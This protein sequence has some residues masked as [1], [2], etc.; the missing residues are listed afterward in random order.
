M[1]PLTL[2]AV[3]AGLCH[4]SPAAGGELYG[5][6]T[7]RE[8]DRH[9]GPIRWDKNENFWDDFLDATKNDRVKVS[10]DEGFDL[11]FF[12]WRIVRS[13][14]RE[15]WVRSQ[16]A[17]PFGHLSSI[18]SLSKKLVVLELKSGERLEI[19]ESGDLGNSMRGVVIYG[20]DGGETELDWD[21]IEKVE[22][23]EAK[24]GFREED[25]LYGTVE[26]TVGEFVGFVVW[27][28]D[29]S[30]R[31]DILDGDEDDR[32]RKVPMGSIRSIENIGNGAKVTLNSGKTLVL[33]GSNDVDG[34]NRG[35]DVTIAEM[36]RVT[37]QWSEFQRV[38]FETPPPS[39]RYDDFD[40]G[41]L[42]HG[43]VTT[44]AGDELGGQIVWDRDER[45][46]W[47]TLSG[48]LR[49]VEFEIHFQYIDR[50]DKESSRAARVRLRDGIEFVLRDSND[51]D[52][53]NKGIIVRAE[54]GTEHEVTW[55]EF[56][57]V[58]FSESSS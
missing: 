38:T 23:S 56:T 47:E 36:G 48:K 21:E 51:V 7:T 42:L 55:E 8:G 43:I 5:T 22:F 29:E 33:T 24:G 58:V 30:I 40:G 2:L 39:P 10:D 1:K 28:K 4:V 46:T 17:V 31:E 18:E 20:E 6:V 53:G 13:G 41:H 32:S 50:I 11:K 44:A 25:R 26:T 16:F 49:G 14:D 34:D 37:V 9:T 57:S 52:K 54:D 35:I 12:G 27:D 45:Y 19:R 15:S 3:L